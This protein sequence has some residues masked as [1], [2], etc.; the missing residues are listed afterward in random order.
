MS[1]AFGMDIYEQLPNNVS[2][3]NAAAG[4]R[5]KTLC[6]RRLALFLINARNCDCASL[7]Q[8]LHHL[9]LRFTDEIV[10]GNGT[11]NGLEERHRVINI[12]YK[13]SIFSARESHSVS[14]LVYGCQHPQ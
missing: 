9:G 7:F 1:I 14:S 5:C 10:L 4:Q 8:G 11:L 12:L 3:N 2:A 13:E 6:E